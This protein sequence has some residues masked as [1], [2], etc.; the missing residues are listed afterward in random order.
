MKQKILRA[1]IITVSLVIA[2]ACGYTLGNMR[3]RKII[4]ERGEDIQKTT[5]AEARIAVVDIDEGVQVDGEVV[6]YGS[7]ILPY[8]GVD[9]VVTGLQDARNGVETGLYSA[10]IILPSDFSQKMYSINTQPAISNLSYIVSPELTQVQRTQALIDIGTFSEN[11]NNSLTKI[12]L[13]SVLKEFHE[14]QDASDTIIKNDEKDAELLDAVN[15]GNLIAMVEL[16]QLTEAPNNIAELN[17]SAQ[18]DKNESLVGEL[19][20]TYKVF[21][22]AGQSDIVKTQENSG[23]VVEDMQTATTHMAGANQKL[24]DT[25]LTDDGEAAQEQYQKKEKEIEKIIEVYDT[26]VASHNRSV[27][28]AKEGLRG[29]TGIIGQYQT[30]LD[31][32]KKTD[33]SGVSYYEFTDAQDY[34]EALADALNHNLGTDVPGG[35]Y[36]SWAACLES[37]AEGIDPDEYCVRKEAIQYDSTGAE[38]LWD[39]I[40]NVKNFSEPTDDGAE[41]VSPSAQVQTKVGEIITYSEQ[42]RDALLEEFAQKKTGILSAYNSVSSD[43]KA[44]QD[45]AGSLDKELGDYNLEGYVDEQQVQGVQNEMTSNNQ[46]IESKVLE[47]NSAHIQY[48]GEVTQAAAE[49]ASAMQQSVSDAQ[50]ESEKLLTDGLEEAKASRKRNNEDNLAMLGG[51]P[52]KLAYTRI[53]DVENKEV[54][55]FMAAPLALTEVDADEEASASLPNGDSAQKNEASSRLAFKSLLLIFASGILIVLAGRTGIELHRQRKERQ[56]AV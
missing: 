36:E 25:S 31:N 39:K 28:E 48:A 27:A 55:D 24:E 29:Q 10:Y 12:Y 54:Y 6:R 42:R 52:G 13:S 40:E 19:D 34:L 26:Y 4:V 50:E 51:F 41:S 45:K 43:Y 33:A 38:A 16:P 22:A 3:G 1:G 35:I 30:M 11:L 46:E 37:M 23:A 9:Y 5:N 18:Y 15:A 21:L 8:A 20:R 53:G 32:A 7:K 14:V 47:N 17:L 2:L 44:A 49:D 56:N